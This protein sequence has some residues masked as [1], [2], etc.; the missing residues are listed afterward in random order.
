MKIDKQ[1]LIELLVEKTE[2]ETAEVEEQLQQLIKRIIDAAERGKALEIKEF[3][4][5]YFDEDGSLR[6]D[7]S[8]ELSTEINFKYAGMEPVQLKP[9]RES[10]NGSAT[11]EPDQP[12]AEAKEETPQP[13][14]KDDG[15][16]DIFGVDDETQDQKDEASEGPK[17]ADPEESD[18][19]EDQ[20]PYERENDPFAGL[21]GD[22]SSK[23]K[24]SGPD[25]LEQNLLSDEA[26]NREEPQ[27]EEKQEPAAE[28]ETAFTIEKK[29]APEDKTTQHIPARSDKKKDPIMMVIVGVLIF[30]IL[31]SAAVLIPG[32]LQTPAPDN[33][34]DENITLDESAPEPPEAADVLVSVEPEAS[35]EVSEVEE[36]SSV[37][38]PD[39]PR[40]GLDG[41]I[42]DAANDGYSIVLHSLR[43]EERARNQAAEL[44]AEGYRVLVGPRTVN[45][46]TVWR[47]SVGQFESIPAAQQQA[48]E[49]PSPYNENN[50]IQRIQ[51][52]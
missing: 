17:D 33:T 48:R 8:R 5:F 45:G 34:E 30:V 13:E 1:Q 51:T 31:A 22:A 49:L 41:D 50:F 44:T 16:D 11:T 46:N 19:I 10:D 20:K 39:Q 26:K 40:Y 7:P 42:V 32:L 2:M 14:E 29:S 24:G 21:L 27:P 38:E 37:P 28:E 23:M 25:D 3:G 35:N 36:D 47:V 18:E 43:E 9:P 6:F 12:D 52:N 4:L 15:F